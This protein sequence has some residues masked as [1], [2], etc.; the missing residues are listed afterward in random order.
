MPARWLEELELREALE[1]A[2]ED[3]HGP[4]HGAADA[5]QSDASL[6]DWDHYPGW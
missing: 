1:R 6:S 2:A 3:L 5:E 4:V